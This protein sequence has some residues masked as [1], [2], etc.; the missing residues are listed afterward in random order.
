MQS[1]DL[2]DL[3]AHVQALSSW[4]RRTA[5]SRSIVYWVEPNFSQVGDLEIAGRS[6]SQAFATAGYSVSDETG[7]LRDRY[8]VD[9]VQYGPDRVP[10]R[11]R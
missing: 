7:L 4:R 11:R 9:S 5:S 10:V 1:A 6:G 2:I 3:R 8:E